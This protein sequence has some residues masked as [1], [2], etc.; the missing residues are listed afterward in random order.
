MVRNI[1]SF[2]SDSIENL[3]ERMG[4]NRLE[5]KAWKTREMGINLDFFF[6]RIEIK[7][8]VEFIPHESIA[9]RK[10]KGHCIQ[11]NFKQSSVNPNTCMPMNATKNNQQT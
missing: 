5:N 3:G 4:D 9:M 7:I 10:Q 11:F 8:V 2:Y 6:M 1:D